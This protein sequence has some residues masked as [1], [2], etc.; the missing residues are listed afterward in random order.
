MSGSMP[1][2]VA[3][4]RAETHD[5]IDFVWVDGR[6]YMRIIVQHTPVFA[7]EETVPE[8]RQLAA[9]ILNTADLAESLQATEPT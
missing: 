9:D 4:V 2:K 6:I 5:G 7:T 1:P 8:L 3:A